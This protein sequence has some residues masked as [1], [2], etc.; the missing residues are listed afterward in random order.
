MNRMTCFFTHDLS[1]L[2][3]RLNTLSKGKLPQKMCSVHLERRTQ[4]KQIHIHRDIRSLSGVSVSSCGMLS[5]Q[6][7]SKFEGKWGCLK[8]GVTHTCIHNL[9]LSPLPLLSL[10]FSRHL[11]PLSNTSDTHTRICTHVAV[12]PHLIPCCISVNLSLHL[13]SSGDNDIISTH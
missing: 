6:R 2:I 8:E 7:R 12:N 5:R 10:S 3:F 13:H 9:L 4:D 1:Q 11:Q